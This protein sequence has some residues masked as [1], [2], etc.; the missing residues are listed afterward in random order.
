MGTQAT[1]TVHIAG[2]GTNEAQ[3]RHLHPVGQGAATTAPDRPPPVTVDGWENEIRVTS[4]T[5]S[6]PY[7]QINWSE[8]GIGR[9]TTAGRTIET[10]QVATAQIIQRLETKAF[11]SDRQ[12]EKMIEAWL[13]PDRPRQKP[14]S[15][16][17]SREQARLAK[18][19]VTPIIG[20]VRCRDLNSGHFQAIIGSATSAG[21]AKDL[22]STVSA[23]LNW[24]F[25][26]G[27]LLTHPGPL[28]SDVVWM[29]P[30]GHPDHRDSKR[31]SGKLA[32]RQVA[33]SPPQEAE[34]EA[35]QLEGIR[36]VTA[37][38]T[39]DSE[40]V[41]RLATAFEELGWDPF[42]VYLTTYS[43]VRCGEEMALQARHFT[44][45]ERTIDVVQAVH[46]KGGIRIGL[47]KWG[48][49]RKTFYPL[50]TPEGYELAAQVKERVAK[51]RRKYGNDGFILAGSQ[52]GLYGANRW[53]GQRFRPAAELA[54]WPTHLVW[55]AEEQKMV[56]RFLWTWH[57]LRH[58]FAAWALWELGALLPDV[59]AAMGH[60][61]L[62]TTTRIYGS[63]LPAGI[64]RLTSL[65]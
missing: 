8:E 23:L 33:E 26:K 36:P 63:H 22:R 20:L 2:A 57:S 40:A 55:S 42:P 46:E 5:A 65:A 6:R 53:G 24:G 31:V 41:L 59:S 56:K 58:R 16:S 48:K 1:N 38:E 19:H 49:T 60:C 45:D 39:P 32:A 21:T 17:H 44:T 50:V 62:S 28:M 25:K 27:Y 61:D 54:G 51:I 29:P 12:A 10:L 64:S 18:K 47:P 13:N 11:M 43:G 37:E 4:P 15:I 52:G 34:A 30:K 14:W 35:E 3:A 7:Y 9:N